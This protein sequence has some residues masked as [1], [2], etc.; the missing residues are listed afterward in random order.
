[1]CLLWAWICP[2]RNDRKTKRYCRS[3][4]Y[5]PT[6]THRSNIRFL[7]SPSSKKKTT[8]VFLSLLPRPILK[9]LLL[10]HL[11]HFYERSLSTVTESGHGSAG[12]DHPTVINCV[13]WHRVHECGR[14]FSVVTTTR[15]SG[16]YTRKTS[17]LK[18]AIRFV[19][20]CCIRTTIENGNIQWNGF[21]RTC[22]LFLP[23]VLFST[24]AMR[25]F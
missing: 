20:S 1:M 4:L 15:S 24:R 8:S 21:E 12:E 25:F 19:A 23:Y 10:L 9:L 22:F 5:V 13:L 3:P 6:D 2:Q 16:R 7:T 11:L 17:R 14:S 18:V